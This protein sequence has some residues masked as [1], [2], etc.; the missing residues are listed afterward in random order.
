MGSKPKLFRYRSDGQYS[1]DS[2]LKG[3][4]YFVCPVELND[5]FEFYIKYDIDK[6]FQIIRQDLKAKTI[7]S[8]M[9]FEHAYTFGD[10]GGPVS[11]PRTTDECIKMFDDAA[12]VSKIKQSLKKRIEDRI[13]Q[14]KE[15][16]GIVSLTENPTEPVMWSHY[17]N[18]SKGF[19]EIYDAE[20]IIWNFKS[21][22]NYISQEYTNMQMDAIGIHRVNYVKDFKERNE[23]VVKLLCTEV[24][25]DCN[26]GVEFIDDEETAKQVLEIATSKLLPWKYEKEIRLILP[27]DIYKINRKKT[28]DGKIIHDHF[29]EFTPSQPTKIVL[30][31]KGNIELEYALKY[32]CAKNN[33]SFEKSSDTFAFEID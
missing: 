33:I 2:A 13:I 28:N 9:L 31:Y 10:I 7:V 11:P 3:K 6:V 5:P 19:L 1:V 32:Y 23:L 12:K 17:T 18:D 27:C 15:S 25:P 24:K 29:F 8:K 30:G 14:F 4:M 21:Y 16:F 22:L 26:I 20:L